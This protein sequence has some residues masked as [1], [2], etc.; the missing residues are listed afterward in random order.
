MSCEPRRALRAT[1]ACTSAA[2]ATMSDQ[3]VAQHCS[4]PEAAYL[5]NVM[6]LLDA[7]VLPKPG[8]NVIRPVSF[9]TVAAGS[10][11]E[12]RKSSTLRLTSR[13]RA[14]NAGKLAWYF[15][16]ATAGSPDCSGRHHARF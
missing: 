15:S 10:A 14:G 4:L 11:D 2:A 8:S 3:G 9:R 7:L 12:R 16:C 6:R 1:V 5:L 13:R